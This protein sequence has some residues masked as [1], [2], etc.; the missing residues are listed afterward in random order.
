MQTGGGYINRLNNTL[1][2]YITQNE[3]TLKYFH[4]FAKIKLNGNTWEVQTVDTISTPGIIEV[5]L[6][7]HSNNTLKDDIDK[8]V[9]N[10]IDIIEVD[11]RQEEHISGPS[12]IYPYETHTYELKNSLLTEG[13]WSISNMSRRDAAKIISIDGLKVTIKVMTGKKANFVL[14]FIADNYQVSLPITVGSL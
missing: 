7:E 10:S 9:Q 8:A 1:Y 5:N 13:T 12:K 14:D 11:D 4:R 3:E 6:K 2:M